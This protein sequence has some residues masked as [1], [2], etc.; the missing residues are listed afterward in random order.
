MGVRRPSDLPD[1]ARRYVAFVADST[2]TPVTFVSVG[3][4]REQFIEM[5]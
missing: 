5:I 4:G 1:A 3:P 2:G